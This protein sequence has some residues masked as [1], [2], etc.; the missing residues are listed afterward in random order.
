MAVTIK[1]SSTTGFSVETEIKTLPLYGNKLCVNTQIRNS[2]DRV[3]VETSVNELK[4]CP[5]KVA[6]L[7]K[8]KC[9]IP[10]KPFLCDN[11][12]AFVSALLTHDIFARYCVNIIDAPKCQTESVKLL[13]EF[14]IDYAEFKKMYCVLPSFVQLSSS[15][16]GDLW[17][18]MV[19]GMRIAIDTKNN[20][21]KSYGEHGIDIMAY[22][23]SVKDECIEATRDSLD[24]FE[25]ALEELS[26]NIHA[27]GD[28]IYEIRDKI[29]DKYV[30]IFDKTK[31]AC[32]MLSPI[33]VSYI[34]LFLIRNDMSYIHV[35]QNMFTAMCIEP[36]KIFGMLN[37]V[38][39]VYVTK[40]YISQE[41]RHKL[42]IGR[43]EHLGL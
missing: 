9:I 29:L 16:G 32:H 33:H 19:N 10:L 42:L 36:R 20:L 43:M 6:D 22:V 31:N 40:H 3:N 1:T 8:P 27:Y 13:S 18:N 24:M 28:R 14:V 17:T 34:L 4:I 38:G 21:L 15:F 11:N 7:I 41:S 30:E 37:G 2:L 23:D 35:F 12:Y 26:N 5:A 25:F 39:A